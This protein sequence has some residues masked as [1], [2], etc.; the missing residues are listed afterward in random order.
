M[1]AFLVA[2]GL[3]CGA[4]GSVV[5][6]SGC[7]AE[8]KTSINKALGRYRAYDG[9]AVPAT[10]LA[11]A[12]AKAKAENKRVL[13]QFG[14]NWCAFCQALDELVERDPT[15]KALHNNYV[16]IHIDAA[17]AED[18]NQRYGKPFDYGF[19]VLLVF[20][21]DGKHLHTQPST[22]FQLPTAIGHD[23]AGVAAFLKTW[24]R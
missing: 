11:N 24:A 16:A 8:T 13:V 19:P 4:S 5:F 20:D 1:R 23:P 22:A 2:L 10:Q 12:V 7:D 6:L 3:L 17:N 14:G 18:M 21:G 15:L 9:A